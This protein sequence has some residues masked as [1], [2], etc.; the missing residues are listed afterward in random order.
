MNHIG[1]GSPHHCNARSGCHRRRVIAGPP[2]YSR[3]PPPKL[4]VA[5]GSSE[6]VLGP[7]ADHATPG[8]SALVLRHACVGVTGGRVPRNRRKVAVAPGPGCDDSGGPRGNGCRRLRR[9]RPRTAATVGPHHQAARKVNRIAAAFDRKNP[10]APNARF[11][12]FLS[13]H[14]DAVS[15]AAAEGTR[16]TRHRRLCTR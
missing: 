10:L 8:P 7:R 11:F 3:R 13:R 16:A 5:G 2:H 9:G 15:A 1:N 12:C 6:A 4:L 14:C